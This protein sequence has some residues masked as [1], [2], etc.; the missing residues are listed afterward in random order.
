MKNY[1]NQVQKITLAV[2]FSLLSFCSVFAQVETAKIKDGTISNGATKARDGAI[3]ELESN[4]KGMLI[5]RMSTAQR[6]AIPSANLSNGLL[7]FNT[8]TNCFDYWDA[9][10]VQWLSM[11]GTPPPAVF[12]ISSVQCS[13]V[14]ANGTYK[15]GEVLTTSNTLTVP[16]TV[17]QPGTYTITATTANGYYFEASGSFPNASTYDLTLR[18]TGR[19]NAGYAAGDPGDVVSLVLNGV[20]TSCSPHIFVEKASVDFSVTCASISALGSYNIGLDLTPANKLTVNVIVTNTGFWSMSTNKVN[21]YSFTGQGTFTTTGPQTVELL[22]TGMPETAGTNIFSLSSNANSQATASCSGIP[23]TVA[24][25]AYTM[26]CAGATQSGAY[27][28]N[29]PLNLTTNTITL[30]INVTATGST[31][32]TTNTVNGVSFSSGPIVLT[33]LGADTVVLK[34]SGT[35]LSGATTALTLTGTPGSSATCSFNLVIAQQPVAYTMTCGTISVSGSYVP[36]QAMTSA[37][38]MTVPVTVTYVGDYNITTSTV[39]GVSFSGTGTFTTTG[40]QSVTLQASGTPVSGGAFSYTISSNSTSSGITCSKAIT[41]VYRTMNI[42]SLGQSLY[43]PGTAGS[44]DASKAILMNASSF[45]PN[46]I[47]QVQ[48]MKIINGGTSDSALKS[49]INNNQVDIIVLAY[50]FTP[51]STSVGIL[52]DFVKNKKGVLI[53]AQENDNG[54]LASLI[55]AICGSSISSG[56]VNRDNSTYINP[57]T[58]V[59]NAITDG[60]FGS[61]KGLSIGGDLNN[62]YSVPQIVNTTALATI[63]GRSDRMTSFVHN[64]L[65]YMFVGDG[66]WAAGTASN[67]ST[68]TYPAKISSTGV[69]LSK[70]YTGSTTVYNSIMYANTLAWAIQYAQTN[71]NTSYVIP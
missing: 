64:T 8:N 70:A 7:V 27:M 62:S 50:N 3:F 21:G 25:V 11:C 42:L 29:V 24:P 35:P 20:V 36:N 2:V 33:K 61:V 23:V 17:T 48:S 44:G 69:P 54:N 46:G 53:Q 65:G 13:E 67:T 10:R 37:N 5:S 43:A 40:A 12:D 15:Q 47:V 71:T 58:T 59:S 1:I 51:N 66:G 52:A 34:G 63:Q 22:G 14:T 26:N 38:T 55:N 16:V 4:N 31:T 19:P 6:N 9:L 49:N 28:Q 68:T 57:L 39:N 32:I 41:F 56:D 30:P 18:G 45:G 60:P